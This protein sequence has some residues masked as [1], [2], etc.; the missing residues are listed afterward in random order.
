MSYAKVTSDMIIDQIEDDARPVPE[1]DLSADFERVREAW[2]NAVNSNC[3]T[4]IHARYAIW[5]AGQIM[6]AH[7]ASKAG[8]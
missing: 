4:K 5:C 8:L 3:P 1:P 6:S 7:L 2:A